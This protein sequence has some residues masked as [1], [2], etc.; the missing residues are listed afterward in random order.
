MGKGRGAYTG[1]VLLAATTLFVAACG[2]GGGGSD[3]SGSGTLSVSL[4]DSP[5]CGF[6]EVNVSVDRVRV[7]RSASAADTDAGWHEIVLPTTRRINLL[8]LTNGTLESLGE[9]QLPAGRYTQ[10]RLVLAANGGATPM[11]NSVVLSGSG[12]EIALTTPSGQQSGLKMNMDVDVPEWKVADVVIDFD[13]CKS[14]VKRGNSGL[15]NL[16]PVLSAITVLSDAGMRVIGYVAPAIAGTSTTV[17]VQ[18]NGVP[19][20]ASPPDANGRFELYPVPAGTYDLVVSAA[21]R[22]TAV[23]TGVPVVNT[24]PTSVN[25][26]GQPI[27]P[28]SSAERRAAGTVLNSDASVPAAIVSALKPLAGGASVEVAAQ[29]TDALGGTYAFDLPVARAVRAAYVVSP[30]V[31]SFAPDQAAPAGAYV[32]EATVDGRAPQQADIDLS[33]A[34]DGEDFVF[35]P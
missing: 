18:S 13:A 28:P 12:N 27:D 8:D 26:A 25:T 19:A 33:T 10:M 24:A 3:G 7:H 1:A 5:A 22:A 20:K 34:P 29:P 4:T 16:K 30:Q 21:G 14:V 35:A 23:V 6:D 17:S 15:Y 31:L 2:G 9:T 32:L 11:A